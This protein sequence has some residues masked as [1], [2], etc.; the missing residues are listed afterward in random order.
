MIS[1]A[2]RANLY[3]IQEQDTHSDD[4]QVVDSRSGA[5]EAMSRGAGLKIDA[6]RFTHSTLQDMK[7]RTQSTL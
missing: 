1:E 4:V 2:D 7:S 3:N 5:G 6:A